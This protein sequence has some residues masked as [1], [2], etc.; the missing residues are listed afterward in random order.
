MYIN[1]AANN[2]LDAASAN[3]VEGQVRVLGT[4]SRLVPG[5][6][7]GFLS[8]EDWLLHDWEYMLRRLAMVK[9]HDMVKDLFS[10][11]DLNLPEDDVHGHIAGPAVVIDAVAIY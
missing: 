1:V 2:F 11:L 5:G 8:A 6:N 10:D 4:V 9:I 7:E 3:R